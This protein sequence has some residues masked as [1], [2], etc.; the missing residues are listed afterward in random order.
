MG[1]TKKDEEVMG[2]NKRVIEGLREKV[3]ELGREIEVL[4]EEIEYQ[5]EQLE[6]R[7]EEMK[8]MTRN[9]KS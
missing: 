6:S 8:Q 3:G 1:I 7:V 2:L 9:F 4:K 5:N